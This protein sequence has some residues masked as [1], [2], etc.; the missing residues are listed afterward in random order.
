MQCFINQSTFEISSYHYVFYAMFYKAAYTR[1]IK[2]YYAF[3]AMFYKA[4]YTRN[5]KCHCVCFMQ[6]LSGSL[7]SKYQ[8]SL[9]VFYAIFYFDFNALNDI[10][11]K[12]NKEI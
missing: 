8:M 12:I 3:Y 7:F 5:I 1:N 10:F 2:C 6:Y 4:A 11:A 9:C